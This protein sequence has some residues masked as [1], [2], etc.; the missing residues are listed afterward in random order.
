TMRVG[1]HYIISEELTLGSAMHKRWICLALFLVFVPPV[2]AQESKLSGRWAIAIHGGAGGNVADVNSP[3]AVLKRNEMERVLKLAVK[4][5]EEGGKAID[6]VTEAIKELED[7]PSF[8]AGRG[9]VL[10]AEGNAELDASIMD[11][12]TRACGAVAAVISIR[13]PIEAAR[14]VM[15]DTKHVLLAGR[16]ADRFASKNGLTTVGRNYFRVKRSAA[17]NRDQNVDVASDPHSK[18]TVGCVVLD[19]HGNLAAGTSTGGLSGKLPGRVGDSPIVGAGTYADN[20]FAAIS[21]TGQGEEFI[22]TALAYD[23]VAQMRYG[24]KTLQQAG[25][26]AIKTSLP[27]KCGGFIAVDREGNF[28]L[29]HSTPSMAAGVA[30][31]NGRFDVGFKFEPL[32]Q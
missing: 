18:G 22:R 11:G 3:R 1:E 29:R 26:F 31:S 9:A 20:R 28:S 27:P 13:N 5:I 14:L 30:D 16:N 7:S 10:N 15:T 12:E 4:K 25:E 24:D 32:K 17:P 2:F 6:V 23:I 21:G 19:R 8:N